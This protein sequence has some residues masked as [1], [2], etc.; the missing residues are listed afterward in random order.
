MRR[1]W[2][3]LHHEQQEQDEEHEHEHE[4]EQE[5]EQEQEQPLTGFQG[6]DEGAS[7]GPPSYWGGPEMP[8]SG[9]SM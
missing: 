5:Q 4:H 6:H 1:Y 8:S 9:P 2:V 7:L 3:K